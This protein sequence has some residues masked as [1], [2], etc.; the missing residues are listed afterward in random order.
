MNKSCPLVETDLNQGMGELL[1]QLPCIGDVA[2]AMVALGSA[3]VGSISMACGPLAHLPRPLGPWS[4][5]LSPI[6]PIFGIF[7]AYK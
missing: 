7:P 2:N 3:Q 5:P 4:P 6:W 1:E